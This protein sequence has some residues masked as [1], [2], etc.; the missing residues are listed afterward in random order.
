MSRA[1]TPESKNQRIKSS[2]PAALMQLKINGVRLLLKENTFFYNI[3]IY[4]I[5]N[6]IIFLS[7]PIL[8]FFEVLINVFY[9]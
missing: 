6:D 8:V 2:I 1:F 4:I 9:V 7:F 3:E 5:L